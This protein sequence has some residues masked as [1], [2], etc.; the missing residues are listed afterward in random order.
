[1]LNGMTDVPVQATG[2]WL[3]PIYAAWGGNATEMARD[4]DEQ[5]VLTNQWRNRGRI[6]ERYW[7][8]IIVKAA[9]RGRTLTHRDFIHPDYR[10]DDL[11]AAAQ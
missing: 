4:I 11:A 7:E 2:E 1:M 3:A 9:A 8:K 10:H 6:P 5:P